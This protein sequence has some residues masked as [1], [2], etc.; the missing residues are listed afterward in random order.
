MAAL[1]GDLIVERDGDETRLVF[2]PQPD[3]VAWEREEIIRLLARDSVDIDEPELV[4]AAIA[5]LSDGASSAPVARK[6]D[7]SFRIDVSG[8]RMFATLT[9][10]KPTGGGRELVLKEISAAII[11]KGFSGLAK[12]HVRDGVLGWYRGDSLELTELP[13]CEGKPPESGV[14]GDIEWVHPFADGESADALRARLALADVADS[15]EQLASADVEKLGEID[16]QQ[17]ICTILPAVA[18]K[19][20]AD[21]FGEALEAAAG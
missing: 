3:G 2:D 13:L 10:R 18:A 21:V 5:S 20:G 9:A 19:P 8:D 12:G 17:I 16:A 4:D 15:E 7:G 1:T 14:D 6:V 11:A